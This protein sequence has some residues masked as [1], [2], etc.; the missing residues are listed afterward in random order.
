MKVD[1]PDRP[2]TLLPPHKRGPVCGTPVRAGVR[3]PFLVAV[4]GGGSTALSFGRELI[5]ISDFV[6]CMLGD[7][8]TYSLSTD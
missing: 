6:P 3:T 8:G 4:A 1:L 2:A 5:R 7:D